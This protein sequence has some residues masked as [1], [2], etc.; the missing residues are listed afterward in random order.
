MYTNSVCSEQT[1]FS[2]L[3]KAE[4]R[5]VSLPSDTSDLYESHEVFMLQCPP[6]ACAQLSLSQVLVPLS[7]GY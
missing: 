1:L 5:K 4:T 2:Y 6:S 7:L 3:S